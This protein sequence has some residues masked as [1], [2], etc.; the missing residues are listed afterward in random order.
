MPKSTTIRR[1]GTSSSNNISIS[2][3]TTRPL[4]K[5]SRSTKTQPPIHVLLLYPSLLV[6]GTLYA[7]I[8]PEANH[9]GSNHRYVSPSSPS[10]PGLASSVNMPPQHEPLSYFARKDNVLNLYFVKVGWFWTT[11]AFA[12][13][14][15]T[16]RAYTAR[17]ERVPRA[18]LRYAL[19]TGSWILTTQWFFGP[20]LIDRGFTITGGK[21]EDVASRGV[22]RANGKVDAEDVG[23]FV[24]GYACKVAGGR[25]NG[26]HDISGHVFMLALGSAFLALEVFGVTGWLFADQAAEVAGLEKEKGGEAPGNEDVSLE[27]STQVSG[28]VQVYATRFIWT[29]VGLQLWMFLMTGIWFHTWLEKVCLSAHKARG[30]YS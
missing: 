24:S 25:W 30:Q 7:I 20:A 16:Q 13:L 4:Q 27:E 21:C 14:L 8:S 10:A 5:L 2:S 6:I 22:L 29:V 12:S 15:A 23:E 17:L 19:V 1:N 28:T 18:L 3:T 9:G 11:L 26:G